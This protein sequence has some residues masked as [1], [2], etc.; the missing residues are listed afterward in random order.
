MKKYIIMALLLSSP[1]FIKTEIV[2]KKE[3]YPSDLSCEQLAAYLAGQNPTATMKKGIFY[4]GI[5][6]IIFSYTIDSSSSSMTHHEYYEN[7]LTDFAKC[8]QATPELIQKLEEKIKN[9]T[10]KNE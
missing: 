3:K 5:P 6:I 7:L 9:C 4:G 1:F 10:A 8:V 2:Q